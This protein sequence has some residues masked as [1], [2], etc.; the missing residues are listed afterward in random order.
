MPEVLEKLSPDR[1][2]QCYFYRP[3]H[4][5]SGRGSAVAALSN[6]GPNG[7]TVSGTWRQQF[8]WCVVEWNRDN[9]FEHP[10]LRYLPDGDLSGLTLTYREIRT[11]CIAFDSKLYDAVDRR[12]LRIWAP[13]AG[14]DE[15]VWYAEL[16]RYAAPVAGSAVPASATFTLAG[17][18][19]ENDY[20][21]LSW[22]DEHYYHQITASDTIA[23]VLNSLAFAVNQSSPT[24]EAAV[25]GTDQIVLTCRQAGADGNL[26]GVLALASGAEQWTP[27]HQLMSGGQSPAQW[28]ITLNFASLRDYTK[29]DPQIGVPIP[30][31]NIRKMRWTWA[32]ALQPGPF[33]R[34]EFAVVVSNWTVTGAN[35]AYRVAGPYSRRFEDD[36]RRIVYTGAWSEERGNFSGGTIRKTTEAGAKCRLDYQAQT[37]HRLYLGSLRAAA[38]GGVAVKVDSE[39]DRTFHLAAPGENF[40][41]RLDL[42]EHGPGSHSVE[43]TVTSPNFYFD[44]FEL[45]VP[46]DTVSEQP[47]NPRQTL[48]TDWDTDHSLA[49]AP[50]RVAW[51]MK[52]LGFTGRANHYAGALLFYEMH[53]PDNVYATGTVAFSGAAEWGAVAQITIAGT[54][55]SRV[56]L[57]TD[58]LESVAKAFEYLINNGS[59]AVWAQAS[60]AVLT[61]QA[62]ALGTAGNDISLA[63]SS[64]MPQLVITVSAPSLAGGVDGK[65]LTDRTVVPRLNRAARDWHRAYFAAL[66]SYGIEAAA[67]FS[68]ELEHGDDSVQTGLAKRY[69]DG[70]PVWLDT[71]ALQTNFSPVSR[72]FW[73][74]VYLDMANLMDE[75]GVTPYLQFGEVQWWYFPGPGA[76]PL[77]WTHGGMPFYD[78]YS[79]TA[80][81]DQ[82]GRPLHVFVSNSES[83]A[84]WPEEAAFLPN[85][86][87]EFTQAIQN[88][89]R[90]AFPQAKFEVLYPPDVNDYPLT[91]V[92]NLPVQWGPGNI[93]VLKT[94]N[95]TYTGSRNLN[96]SRESI[97]LPLDR[98]FP[99]SRAAHLVGVHNSSEPWDWERRL[100][101]GELC[102]SVVLFALDQFTMIGYK[103]PLGAG[104]RRTVFLG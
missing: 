93:D 49:L 78:S 76:N 16:S 18:L 85:L 6:A 17:T 9:A 23:G 51:M 69:P 60:G 31:A 79:K 42:G 88:F 12:F 71:P 64:S 11:N 55:Y 70:Q 5:V 21:E 30:A 41:V 56:T 98:G 103:V 66:K 22:L 92:V 25:Q 100:A 86:I 19:A 54:V 68:M 37:A 74:Q 13:D 40:V 52:M 1:D 46:V 96:K 47:E 94:E 77:L 75:A 39:P 28:E 33:E 72:D 53:I 58:T 15:Q 84:P 57:I 99:R 26:L 10:V 50:E 2:L 95:F 65:W 34:S 44:F 20:V 91:R 104:V 63:A 4:P 102:E 62:R 80:F 27:A 24:V 89:V 61:I 83:P 3:V 35:R 14:G 45:A 90:A 101:M 32:A 36:D 38:V 29:G 7:F 8:D 81:E 97:R 87:G 43:L 82:F 67:A 59:T 48:A 73:K